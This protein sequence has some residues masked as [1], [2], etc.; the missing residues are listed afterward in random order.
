MNKEP[1]MSEVIYTRQ[2]D[3][4]GHAG[5][6]PVALRQAATAAELPQ[7]SSSQSAQVA[8]SLFAA[9]NLEVVAGAFY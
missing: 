4:S 1:A 3:T 6:L 2:P 7:A 8:D 9:S 5:G